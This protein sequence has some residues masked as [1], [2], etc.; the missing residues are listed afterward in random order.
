MKRYI[1]GLIFLSSVFSAWAE[2]EIYANIISDERSDWF[3]S[4]D[5]GVTSLLNNDAF[6]PNVFGGQTEI[7][8]GVWGSKYIGIRGGAS[9]TLKRGFC[10]YINEY[11][12]N[13]LSKYSVSAW[14]V[15]G[16]LLINASS[17]ICN[18]IKDP[19]YNAVL[20]FGGGFNWMNESVRSTRRKLGVFPVITCGLQNN[21]RLSKYVELF[22]DVSGDFIQIKNYPSLTK[23]INLSGGVTFY[24]GNKQK[25]NIF[26]KEDVQPY[27]DREQKILK[28]RIAELERR[29]NIIDTIYHTEYVDS[30]AYKVNAI[31]YFKIN[32]SNLSEQ[33]KS[34]LKN[35]ANMMK[36][37]QKKM[38]VVTGWADNYTGGEILNNR[39]RNNR[40]KAVKREL[41][42]LGVEP[43]SLILQIN[44]GEL[45]D[46]GENSAAL[47]RAVTITEE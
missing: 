30:V 20:H 10:S 34:V 7:F 11:N 21:F 23:S 27:L 15:K 1:I 43:S 37:S 33:A 39:L 41:V 44:N 17:L 32:D 12:R 14:G 36:N 29:P 4:L 22:A 25:N 18:S 47:N 31:I 28:E 35:T 16:E 19:I 42:K 38:F 24:L 9:W 8:G 2:K 13:L 46:L 40:A 45:T 3:L 26:Y 6:N 5:G